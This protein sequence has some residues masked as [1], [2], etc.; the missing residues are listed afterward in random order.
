MSCYK[1]ICKHMHNNQCHRATAH[2]HL[3][4][5]YDYIYNNAG[6]SGRAV[7]VIGLRPLAYCDLGF[8]STRGMNVC[9]LCVF[10]GRSLCDELITRP[11]ESYRQGRVV[12][13]DQETSWMR[14]L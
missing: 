8:E 3:N 9:L 10:S 1:Y 6:P 11:E 13:C 5:N 2:L 7:K 14:R 12:V 4:Y